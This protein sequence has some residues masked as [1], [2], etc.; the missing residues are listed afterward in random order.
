MNISKI[1]LGQRSL[2]GLTETALTESKVKLR[3]KTQRYN[4]T[5]PRRK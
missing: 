5:S 2:H 1:N 4:I 3:T